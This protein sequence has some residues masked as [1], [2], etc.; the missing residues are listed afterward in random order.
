MKW[1]RKLIREEIERW[2]REVDEKKIKNLGGLKT[3]VKAQS[4]A[5]NL[6]EEFQKVNAELP[7]ETSAGPQA[8]KNPL[9]QEARERGLD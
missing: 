4:S 2:I 3:T 1:L 9:L 5:R 7:L 6:F 8:E